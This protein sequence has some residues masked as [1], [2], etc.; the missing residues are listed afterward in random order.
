MKTKEKK[1]LLPENSNQNYAE[2][3]LLQLRSAYEKPLSV[4]IDASDVQ[5][6]STAVLQV[7]L[8]A[9]QTF[10]KAGKKIEIKSA[11]NGFSKKCILLAIDKL[12]VKAGE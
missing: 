12:N 1:I 10:T 3:L 9:F 7:L 6:I 4:V 5:Q 2:E 8:S 11:S